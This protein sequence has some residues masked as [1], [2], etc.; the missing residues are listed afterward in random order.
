MW[1]IR[2]EQVPSCGRGGIGRS[3]NLSVDVEA[4][5]RAGCLS[6]NVEGEGSG[7]AT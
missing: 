7:W 4:E 6:I 1:R 3:A 5:G 2:G